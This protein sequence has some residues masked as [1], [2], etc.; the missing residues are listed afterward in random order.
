MEILFLGT[1]EAFGA[2]ANTS[3]LVDGRIL[4]DCGLTTVNQL[5]K[6]NADLNK[7][8]VIF[9]SH[10][11]MD[12]VFGVPAFLSACRKQKR[13]KPITIIGP[14][15]TE[16]YIKQLLAVA[17]KTFSDYKYEIKT[18]DAA[19]T[20]IDGYSF[21]FADMHHTLPTKAVSLSACGKKITYTGDGRPSPEALDLMKNSDLLIAEA[22]LE[23]ND[24]HSSIKE[25]VSYAKTSGAKNLALIHISAKEDL[26]PKIKQAKKSFPNLLTP[27][28]MEKTT[29]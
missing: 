9:I 14:T 12:H 13:T 20:T 21:S 2:K 10:Y 11:H 17:Q 18:I 7:I 26:K 25:T 5:F 24:S 19:E 16:E 3:I 15:N 4:L 27:R 29:L 8:S 28:D 1:G 6:A 23:E 22:Y